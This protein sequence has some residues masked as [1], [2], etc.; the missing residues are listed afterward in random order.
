MV[1]ARKIF[2]KSSF[3]SYEERIK[4][5]QKALELVRSSPNF[6]I[7]L[8]QQAFRAGRFNFARE[9]LEIL[10][11]DNGKVQKEAY[12]LR[13][14]MLPKEDE[15]LEFAIIAVDR[16]IEEKLY[17]AALQRC[18]KVEEKWKESPIVKEKKSFILQRLQG[19][20]S[21]T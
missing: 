17:D 9:L 8:A 7:S 3:E 12:K 21:T 2:I 11:K 13:K 15:T 4:M 6:T 5:E 19:D 10:P 16:L 20:N 14:Q 1:Q 18:L